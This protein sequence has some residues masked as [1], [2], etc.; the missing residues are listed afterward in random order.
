MTGYVVTAL[1]DKQDHVRCWVTALVKRKGYLRA[2]VVL[3]A[4]NAR[5]I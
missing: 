5:L 3:A 4:R 2:V 1:K